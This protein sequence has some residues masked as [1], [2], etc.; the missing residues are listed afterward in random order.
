MDHANPASFHSQE[1][2]H[3]PS[4]KVRNRNDEVCLIR[5]MARLGGKTR[6]KLRGA[7]IG[8]KDEKIVECR[9]LLRV[10]ALG[11]TLI[12]AVEKATSEPEGVPQDFSR[13]ISRLR[14]FQ[15][16]PEAVRP[17]LP[18]KALFR[19]ANGKSMQQFAGIN[20]HTREFTP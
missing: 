3:L 6:T 10:A 2:M 20:P 18:S 12:Q 1:G 11:K 13:D 9:D 17:V 16:S 7:V 15:G 8:G 19:M 5:C 4:G 14:F